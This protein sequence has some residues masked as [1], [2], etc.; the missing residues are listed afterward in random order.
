MNRERERLALEYVEESLGW[1]RDEREWR[2]RVMLNKDPEMLVEVRALL[3][4]ADAANSSMPTK[5]AIEAATEDAPPPERIGPYRLGPLLGKGGMG[6]VFRADRVDGVFEQTIAIKLMRRSRMPALLAAQFARERQILARFQHRNIAQLYDGGVTPDGLSYFVM[7][8]VTGRA[9]TQYAREERL[10]LREVLLL[11]MQVCSAVKY[12]HAHLVVHADI[13]PN[14]IIVTADGIAKLLDFGVARVLEQSGEE[15]ADSS[16]TLGLT[17]DYASPARQRG[18]APTTV[19]DVYSLGVLL[20][21][22]LQPLGKLAPD[23]CSIWLRAQ[24]AD[25]SARYAS[26]GELQADVER[27]LD[28]LPV[29]AHGKTWPYVAGRFLSRHR[30]GAALGAAACLLLIGASIGLAVMYVRAEHAK[31][32]AEQRFIDLRALSRYVLFDVYDRLEAIPRSLTLRRD[33]AA[34]GQRYLDRLAHDPNA[35]PEVRIEVIEGLRRLAQ[36]QGSPNSA[37]LAQVPLA[38]ANLDR[39]EALA[40]ALPADPETWRRRALMLARI[41]LARSIIASEQD[42]D[43]KR[44]RIALGQAKTLSQSILARDPLDEDAAGLWLDIAVQDAGTLEWQGQYQQSIEIARAALGRPALIAPTQDARRAEG[45]RRARLLDILGEAIYYGGDQPG[46]EAPYREEY[47]LLRDLAVAEPL[48][49][50]ISRRL[51]RAGWGL[52]ATL[53]DTGR[54]QEGERVLAEARALAE[55]L[56]ELEPEDRDLARLVEI[57]SG[58]HAAGLVALRRFEEARPVLERLLNDSRR[59]SNAAPQDWQLMRDSAIDQQALADMFADAGDASQACAHYQGSLAT[60]AKIHAAGK[61]SQLDEDFS[62]PSIYARLRKMCP[63]LAR[64]IP[65]QQRK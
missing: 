37:T 14:N 52:G 27:W 7:E 39:A 17:Y 47:D 19:D 16:N 20:G 21:E 9:I 58:A 6:R 4:A 65:S 30:L 3:A 57:T 48:N 28:G 64:T 40:H 2:L 10:P 23:L 54:A 49:V 60:F 25:V 26:V 61:G 22:L 62:L 55:R 42:L 46:S 63:E 45:L 56:A 8:L 13:K 31:Q 29:V 50:A 38:R 11:F 41:A 15:S 12:A 36:V 5:M 18:D 35:P 33:I 34:A 44:A 1:H 32:Q 24:A 51:V 53:V 43:F 59:R